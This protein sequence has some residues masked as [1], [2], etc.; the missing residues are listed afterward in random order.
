MSRTV[1]SLD[2]DLGLALRP[3]MR[4]VGLRNESHRI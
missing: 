2:E 4:A 1:F 3:S